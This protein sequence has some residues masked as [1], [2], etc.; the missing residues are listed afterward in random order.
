MFCL[1]SGKAEGFTITR[2]DENDQVNGRYGNGWDSSFDGYQGRV[3]RVLD[4]GH[5]PGEPPGGVERGSDPLFF[6]ASHLD[7]LTEVPR[8][9]VDNLTAEV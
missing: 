8:H 1:P 6:G 3:G 2:A 9:R 4:P 7:D 5:H